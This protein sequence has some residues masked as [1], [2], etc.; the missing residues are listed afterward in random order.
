MG[1]GDALTLTEQIHALV[2]LYLVNGDQTI[3]RSLTLKD[4]DVAG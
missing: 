2:V 1:C 3:G 4:L